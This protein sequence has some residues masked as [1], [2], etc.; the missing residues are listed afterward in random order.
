[1]GLIIQQFHKSPLKNNNYLVADTQ[2]KEAVLIDCSCA[3]DE[4]IN[5]AKDQ[6]FTIKYILLTH[7]HFDHVLGV[8]Y[9]RDNYGIDA[10]IHPKDLELLSRIN[11]YTAWLK[12]PE[13][14]MPQ[15]KS[16]DKNTKFSVGAYPI[17]IIESPGHT[18]GGV[19]Y[20][21]DGNL[22]SGDTLFHGTCGRTDLKES[23]EQAM[24]Q[25]LALL[26]KKLPD[27]T[28]VYPGHGAPTTIGHERWLY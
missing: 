3:D 16:F 21:I 2:T 25:S 1:M 14:E 23:D 12:F 5:W 18:Q 11:E 4:V 13:V 19:C 10:Y 22:F 6:G 20:L 26:F 8:N 28:A 27:E 24:Q 17:E 15:V 7:G 9:Y